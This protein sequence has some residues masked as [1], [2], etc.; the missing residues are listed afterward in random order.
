MPRLDPLSQRALLDCARAAIGRAI[1]APAPQSSSMAPGIL[2]RCVG[3]FVTVRVR[4]ELRGCIGYTDLDLPLR[5]VIARCAAGAAT[6]DPRFPPIDAAEWTD[7]ALEISLLG[8]IEPVHDLSEIE[9]GRHGLIVE[10][11]RHHA[12]LLPQV[13]VEWNWDRLQF[14]ARVCA[15]AG[16]PRDAWQHG[17][18]LFRFEAEVFGD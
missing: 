18:R 5:E 9:V 8:P 15:K 17:A 3:A 7:M 11:G 6:A 16:L 1:G 13:A 10:M 12:L 4:E 14:V 2:D